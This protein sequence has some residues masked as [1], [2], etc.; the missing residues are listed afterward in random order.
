MCPLITKSACY[1][2]LVMKIA[3][4]CLKRKFLKNLHIR[5]SHLKQSQLSRHVPD[6]SV[7]CRVSRFR[8]YFWR[9]CPQLRCTLGRRD[10]CINKASR[11]LVFSNM[12]TTSFLTSSPVKCMASG[13]FPSAQRSAT[14]VK[15]QPKNV[16]SSRKRLQH[17]TASWRSTTGFVSTFSR[18]K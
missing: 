17:G 14:S 3:N 7:F 9:Q 8:E 16:T 1:L 12:A 11:R 2:G 10:N 5:K 13:P 6:Q 4:K 15:V 18:R